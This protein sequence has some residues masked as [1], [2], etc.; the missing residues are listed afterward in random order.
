[1]RYT[2]NYLPLYENSV[3]EAALLSYQAGDHFEK[4]LHTDIDVY[5]I[6]SGKCS[7]DIAV[8]LSA[9]LRKIL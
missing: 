3:S 5:L 2:D 7:M 9:A 8:S 1:M 6:G 4:Y